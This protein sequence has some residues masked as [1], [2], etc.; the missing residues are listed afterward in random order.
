M[1]SG[2]PLLLWLTHVRGTGEEM[3]VSLA[4]WALV[5]TSGGS[6]STEAGL[7]HLVTFPSALS[8][9]SLVLVL[10]L[11]QVHMAT[12]G[13]F[14]LIFG[15]ACR[16]SDSVQD[17]SFPQLELLSLL[18]QLPGLVLLCSEAGAPFILREKMGF[19]RKKCCSSRWVFIL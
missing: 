15:H 1:F 14:L 7:I 17:L 13:F 4:C 11:P 12:G 18:L 19:E 9:C 3:T 16:F 2:F 10:C 6:H 5:G 8:L